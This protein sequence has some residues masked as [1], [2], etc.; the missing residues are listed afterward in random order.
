MSFTHRKRAYHAHAIQWD[1][2]NLEE[3]REL[4]DNVQVHDDEHLMVRHAQGPL[5]IQTLKVGDWVVQ[6]ENGVVKCY[7]DEVFRT[8]YEGL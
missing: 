1:G 4:L 5:T 7:T 6:G 2:N 8:K 3:L